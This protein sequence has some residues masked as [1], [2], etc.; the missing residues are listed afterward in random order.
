MAKNKL[1]QSAR[2]EVR[3]YVIEQFTI[4]NRIVKP[5][6]RFLPTFIWRLVGSI[7]ID[8]QL[9][10]KY[11]Q[12]G[13]EAKTTYDARESTKPKRTTNVRHTDRRK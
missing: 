2:R 7:F 9:L 6:P 8:T 1:Q 3:K 5:K 13:V 12:E 4:M 10:S 11:L